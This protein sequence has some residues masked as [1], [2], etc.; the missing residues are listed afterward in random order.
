[1]IESETHAQWKARLFRS[2]ATQRVPLTVSIELCWSC[3]LRCTH[4][5]LADLRDESAY[6]PID[7]LLGLLEDLAAAGTLTLV[8]TGGEPL[9]HPQFARF[10]RRA[11][12]LGFFISL[13][14]N[15]SLIDEAA[16]D[17]L[18]AYPPH[19]VEISLYGA[20]A[21]TY[22]RVT[23]DGQ[24]YAA[25]LRAIDLLLQRGVELRLK[26]LLMQDLF[27]ELPAMKK[28]AEDRGLRL[29]IDPVVD[30]DLS[31]NT[32][33]YAKRLDPL[34]AVALE[35]AEPR[36]AQNM[37]QYDAEQGAQ[38]MRENLSCGAAHSACHV[39]PRGFLQPCVMLREPRFDLRKQGFAQ[40]WA[41]LA[42]ADPVRHAVDSA[43]ASCDVQHLC[44]Y[45]PGLASQRSGDKIQKR[46][47]YCEI[48]RARRDML[49]KAN[50]Q[51]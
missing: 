33:S 2:V 50:E 45:C 11:V 51:R 3:N 18:A 13:F 12:E 41:A 14:S 6:L 26:M 44:N 46:D 28:I 23:G 34:R 40:A 1:M 10:Y 8:I 49:Q 21:R 25:T 15:G 5:Y 43:C 38:A 37:C 27:G 42:A 24:A 31:G 17:L 48:A 9:L 35:L 20:S 39:D 4:C 22:E 32:N 19:H 36:R 16:A 47:Y 7:F 30:G 29:T